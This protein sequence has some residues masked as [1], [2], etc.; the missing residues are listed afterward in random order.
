MIPELVI[1]G[2]LA[3]SGAQPE[4][5]GGSREHT[6]ESVSQEHSDRWATTP[7]S[8]PYWESV[9]ACES[10]GDWNAN[11][12]NGYFGELQFDRQTWAAFGGLTYAPRAD[13]ATKAEQIA[14]AERLIYDGWPNC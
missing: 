12:G 9:A 3:I 1:S 4:L 11:T 10:G 7:S 6:A 14:V 2:V 5:E 13:L 8:S